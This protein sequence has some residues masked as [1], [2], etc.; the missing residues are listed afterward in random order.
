MLFTLTFIVGLDPRFEFR[1]T[2]QAVW[3]RDGPL[4]MDPFRFN[5]VEPWTFAGQVADDDAYTRGTPLD[6]LIVLAYPVPHDPAA[7]PGGVISDQPQ[8]G[9][10]LGGE[11]GRAPG[12]KIDRDRTHG[13][14]GHKPEPHL[15]GLRRLRPPQQAITGERLG[16]GIVCRW[17]QL[18]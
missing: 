8:R 2:Q 10:A 9:E 11:L 15:L 16:S 1:G 7:M 4:P 6:L 12:Q 5:R 14:P 3:F 13:A 18:L 17:G